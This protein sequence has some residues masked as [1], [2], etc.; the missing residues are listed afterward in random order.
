MK[1]VTLMI[2][3]AFNEGGKIPTEEKK[4]HLYYINLKR[5][6]SRARI[7]VKHLPEPLI[8]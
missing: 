5:V 2:D 3:L 4:N 7:G 8:G 1:G 6:R